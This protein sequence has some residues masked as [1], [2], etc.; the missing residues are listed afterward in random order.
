MRIRALVGVTGF[1]ILLWALVVRGSLAIDLGL[2][3]RS[4]PL[5]P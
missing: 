4:R 2:G 1:G 5:G 3:R